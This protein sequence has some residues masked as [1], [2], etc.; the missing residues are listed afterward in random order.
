MT[1]FTPAT[2]KPAPVI[3]GIA[4]PS[5]SGKT[6]S[7]LRIAR[8]LVGLSGK[9][10]AVDTEY[11]R[12]SHYAHMF[13]FDA[14]ELKEPYAPERYL[15]LWKE[16]AAAGYDVVI[17]DSMS[18]MHEG[19]GGLLEM[20]QEEHKRLGGRDSSKFKSWIRPKA[21]IKKVIQ[22]LNK[23]PCHMILCFR[24]KEKLQMVKQLVD[25]KEKIVPTKSDWLPITTA[26]LEY[27]NTAMLVLPP[28]SDGRPNMY[29]DGRKMPVY[30]RTLFDEG[31]QLSEETGRKLAMWS[32]DE[33]PVEPK[34]SAERWDAVKSFAEEQGRKGVAMFAETAD[35]EEKAA[36]RLRIKE[37]A[38]LYPKPKTE[39]N[40]NGE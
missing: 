12:M 16:A 33:K 21:E 26:G 11:D 1:S 4:G 29:A 27:E 23:S 19:E 35:E 17:T 6:L 7:A 5:G 14:A 13:K 18:H 40:D 24:A 10:A 25:G 8:G 38:A 39:E 37:L 15:E 28:G 32:R 36:I 2:R 34:I 30:F 31:E 3:L 22:Y 20:Q 9:I